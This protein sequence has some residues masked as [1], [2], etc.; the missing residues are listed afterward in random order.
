MTKLSLYL[1][2]VLS[3]KGTLGK[4]MNLYF[5]ILC[6]LAT[7]RERLTILTPSR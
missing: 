7:L 1:S 4:K 3:S 5:A 2:D 6:V